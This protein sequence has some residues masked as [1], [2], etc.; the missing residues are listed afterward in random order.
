MLNIS[1]EQRPEDLRRWARQ[2]GNVRAAAR[3]CAIANALEGMSRADAARG[4]GMERQA[5]RDAVIRYNA[6]GLDGLYSRPP[7]GRACVLTE[8]EQAILANTVFK[9]PDPK[10]DGVCTWTCDALAIWISK[11]F[12]KAIHP[13]SVGRILRR[14]GLSRQKARAVHPKADPKAQERFQKKTS[15][16]C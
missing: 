12:G 5:L 4:A 10:E 6:E 13:D 1:Q 11:A 16:P 8:S 14:N 15:A 7:P 3:A 2:C 9:G